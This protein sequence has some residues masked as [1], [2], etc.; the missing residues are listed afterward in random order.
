MGKTVGA[1]NPTLKGIVLMALAMLVIT[2]VDVFGKLLSADHSPLFVS[3]ARYLVAAAIVVP[4]SIARNGR[5]FLPRRNLGPHLLRTIFLMAAMSLYFLALAE[6]PMAT[7]NSVFFVGPIIG[8]VL[9]VFVLGERLTLR[10]ALALALGFGGALLIVQPGTDVNVG[11]LYALG[12][13]LF[14]GFYIVATRSASLTSDP[15]RTLTFQCLVGALIMLP[16][17]LY[18]WSVPATDL[19]PMFLIMGL[20]SATSHI[21]SITAF[22]LAD[23]STLSPLVYLELV[24]SALFGYLVFN[25]LP[26][27]MVWIGA[28]V[29]V[30]GGLLLIP[31][32]NPYGSGK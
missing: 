2:S 22:S 3:W 13:G 10:K 1:M 26:G 12:A 11:V 25:E 14:F 20:L 30:C 23:A 27:T 9:A 5:H 16:Q 7:A 17:A 24:G 28:T 29:I 8:T 15:L 4:L 18:T 21:M 32:K 19:I 31:G 6:I